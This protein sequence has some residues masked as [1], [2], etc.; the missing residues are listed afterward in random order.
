MVANA[1]TRTKAALGTIKN[2]TGSSMPILHKKPGNPGHGGAGRGQ[3]R[4]KGSPD[5][6]KPLN[7]NIREQLLKG[8]R[9]IKEAGDE[10]PDD[11]TPLDVML[12]AMRSAYKLGGSLMAFPYA[13]K[14]APYLHAR[15]AQIQ[16]RDP[17]ADKGDIRFGWLSDDD[18]KKKTIDAVDAKLLGE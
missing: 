13:E 1:R 17:N 9:I 10:L 3:G 6:V 11:A 4:P 8:E 14:A 15:I 16:L 12:M 7:E 2:I 5:K 18:P